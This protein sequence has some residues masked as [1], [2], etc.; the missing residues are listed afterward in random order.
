MHTRKQ[1]SVL[2]GL[3]LSV[4]LAACNISGSGGGDFDSGPNQAIDEAVHEFMDSLNPEERRELETKSP[5]FRQQLALFY[6]EAPGVPGKPTAADVAALLQTAW[7]RKLI[8]VGA[9]HNV[10]QMALPRALRRDGA[11]LQAASILL[12]HPYAKAA[13]LCAPDPRSAT[14]QICTYESATPGVSSSSSFRDPALRRLG[15][16]MDGPPEA[17]A[18]MRRILE[19]RRLDDLEERL[20]N[21]AVANCLSYEG[22]YKYT[23]I[24]DIAKNGTVRL[25][26]EGIANATLGYAISAADV[27]SAHLP[28]AL[29]CDASCLVDVYTDCIRKYDSEEKEEMLLCVAG[30]LDKREYLLHGDGSYVSY[31]QAQ[32]CNVQ[33]VPASQRVEFNWYQ[34]GEADRH[35][36]L[37]ALADAF[38][39]KDDLRFHTSFQYPPDASAHEHGG[40]LHPL[41]SSASLPSRAL[42]GVPSR[43][44]AAMAT[45]THRFSA[46]RGWHFNIIFGAA[47]A[48]HN[49]DTLAGGRCRRELQHPET[50]EVATGD[51][52]HVYHLTAGELPAY[53]LILGLS[54]YHPALLCLEVLPDLIDR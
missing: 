54:S 11:E 24:I 6:A 8:D 3:M 4:A 40:N 29:H 33:P 15:K 30:K 37:P 23:Y 52:F 19:P 35:Y 31:S 36:E 10:L 45:W 1:A 42:P 7:D 16:I 41:P 27:A 44:A 20:G 50:G 53:D 2:V 18:D 49:A 5:Q 22:L 21:L 34:R 38:I 32:E 26:A 9:A 13:G 25:Y 39:D 43:D 28:V 47:A 17:R 51:Q 14:A 12:V 48:R 46:V